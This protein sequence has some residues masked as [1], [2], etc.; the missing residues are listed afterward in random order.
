M[1]FAVT[2]GAAEANDDARR[3]AAAAAAAAVPAAVVVASMAREVW[4]GGR[5]FER[6]EWRFESTELQLRDR[7]RPLSGATSRVRS[8]TTGLLAQPHDEFKKGT[9]SQSGLQRIA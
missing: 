9:L 8:L 7:M 4:E 3:R 5:V 2:D 6:E 1:T